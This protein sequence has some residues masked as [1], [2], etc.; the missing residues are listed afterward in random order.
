MR[1]VIC[2][3]SGSG[4]TRLACRYLAARLGSD[5]DLVDVIKEPAVDVTPYGVVGLAA[6][7]DFWGMPRYFE[8][9]LS[10]LPAQ[11]GKPSSRASTRRSAGSPPVR[12][13]S[14]PAYASDLWA[15]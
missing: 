2:Y 12:S 14:H 3:Y 11:V 13:S 10:K 15:S 1:G 7:T 4:N 9:F 8:T 5:F 6:S